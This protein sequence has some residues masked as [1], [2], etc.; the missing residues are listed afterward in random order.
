MSPTQDA[1][2]QHSSKFSGWK[3]MKP[4]KVMQKNPMAPMSVS[5]DSGEPAAM[6][7]PV[8]VKTMLGIAVRSVSKIIVLGWVPP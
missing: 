4:S 8:R 7:S 5:I 1:R 2:A 3:M 6:K